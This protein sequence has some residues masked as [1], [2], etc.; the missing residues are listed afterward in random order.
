[1]ARRRDPTMVDIVRM[2][3]SGIRTELELTDKAREVGGYVV[4]HVSLPFQLPLNDGFRYGWD[5]HEA[6]FLELIHYPDDSVERVG[7]P[8]FHE[9]PDY[10]DMPAHLRSSYTVV[11]FGMPM[12]LEH[13]QGT[14]TF[15]AHPSVADLIDR[16]PPDT[17]PAVSRTLGGLLD[18]GV[19]TLD[20][21]IRS[22]RIVTKDAYIW[23]MEG[24]GRLPFMLPYTV[25]D[26]S[27]AKDLIFGLECLER[28]DLVL[29]GEG[30]FLLR[31]G[32]AVD[33][34]APGLEGTARVVGLASDALRG[35]PHPFFTAS[36][37][38]RSAAARAGE[39]DHNASVIEAVTA[40]E[41]Y[42]SA[43]VRLDLAHRGREQ[44]EID[45]AL[46]AGFRNLLKDHVARRLGASFDSRSPANPLE[47]W[48]ASAYRLRNEV[49]HR[50]I[51]V[52]PEQAQ[53]TLV[54][55][56]EFV[57]FIRSRMESVPNKFSHVLTYFSPR[58]TQP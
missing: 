3:M 22:H 46:G 58:R 41:T 33:R 20:F 9:T 56:D 24:P 25:W 43:F 31:M 36:D 55:T 13:L 57:G 48:Y 30:L 2:R 10:G 14:G 17:R 38:M 47:T 27:S 18:E 29:V 34:E 16:F 11:R 21:I 37:L 35:R 45:N 39:G 53:D 28:E 52:T 40:V 42:V 6:K 26:I 32:K 1:M 54:R 7:E 49:V 8:I 19:R 23:P 15:K 51:L 5:D 50:G 44:D 12:P 4:L